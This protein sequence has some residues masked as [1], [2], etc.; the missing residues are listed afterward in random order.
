MKK[1][2]FFLISLLLFVTIQIVLLR[3]LAI[4]DV[5][6]DLILIGVVYFSLKH[7]STLGIPI[8]FFLGCSRTSLLLGS[9][10]LTV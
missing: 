2:I 3:H 4:K 10:G 7:G 1:H 8:G 5:T 9:S 6:P